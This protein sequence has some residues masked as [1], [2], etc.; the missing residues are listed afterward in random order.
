MRSLL[1]VFVAGFLILTPQLA[2]AHAVASGTFQ[3]VSVTLST[4]SSSTSPTYCFVTDAS[5]PG[6]G[7]AS[8]SPEGASASRSWD[9]PTCTVDSATGQVVMTFG[10]SNALAEADV[11]APPGPFWNGDAFAALV[12]TIYFGGLTFS[13]PG[14]L[15]FGLTGS[16]S[17]F[18]ST[19]FI[20]YIQPPSLLAPPPSETAWVYYLSLGVEA[21]SA[22]TG[23]WSTYSLGGNADAV[24]QGA[25]QTL[26]GTLPSTFTIPVV[27]GAYNFEIYN[28]IGVQAEVSNIDEPPMGLLLITVLAALYV[29]R[30]SGARDLPG[31][32][33]LGL[34]S[35]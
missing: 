9:F 15:T 1:P 22:A 24:T 4:A 17:A 33:V 35:P 12:N 3:D 26:S 21:Y 31:S 29:L 6:E 27:A 10:N 18:E 5:A 8:F 30:V 16:Y 19:D 14:S 13:E 7:Y 34:A 32:R 11:G 20:Q 28:I 2:R 23:H 25:S